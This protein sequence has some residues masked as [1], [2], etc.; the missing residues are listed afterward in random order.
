MTNKEFSNQDALFREA[1]KL[2]RIEPSKRQASKYRNG[3]GLARTQ[4]AKAILKV[5]ERG[6]K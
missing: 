5:A 3:R 1:C 2:A 6:N 4:K